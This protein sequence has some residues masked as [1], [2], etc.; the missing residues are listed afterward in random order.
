M[1]VNKGFSGAGQRSKDEGWDGNEESNKVITEGGANIIRFAKICTKA[2][3][4]PGTFE[5][6]DECVE[7]CL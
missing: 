4:D 1:H 6:M 7:E 5:L 2:V 3:A